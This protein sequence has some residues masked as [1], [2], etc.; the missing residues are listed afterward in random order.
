M[1]G[2][3]YI[4]LGANK[5]DTVAA[6]LQQNPSAFIFAFEPNPKLAEVL[7]LRFANNSAVRVLEVACWIMDGSTRFY[8]GHD[9]S[10]TL[11]EGKAQ[12]SQF[13]QFDIDY[14]NSI[15]VKTIDIARWML[16]NFSQSDDIVVKMDIEGSEYKVLQRLL[17]TDAI[18]L[19]REIRCEWHWNRYPVTREE[20][21]RI[22]ALVGTK[23]TLV[24]WN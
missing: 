14:R 19:I 23:V 15:F 24:D 9:E 20:H 13:P 18:D 4:D 16:E 12:N 17:D 7:R 5:G 3:V 8:I 10:S 11:V 2:S 22:K 21:E 1:S 6:Y